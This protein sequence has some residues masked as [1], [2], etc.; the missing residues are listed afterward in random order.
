MTLAEHELR[1][2]GFSE[3]LRVAQNVV[4]GVLKLPDEMSY[5]EGLRTLGLRA[6]SSEAGGT[7]RGQTVLVVGTGTTGLLHL[8]AAKVQSAGSIPTDVISYRLEAAKRFGQITLSMQRM[9]LPQG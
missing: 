8:Q 2:R 6:S 9:M 3:Y 1:S 5:E 7:A 4:D